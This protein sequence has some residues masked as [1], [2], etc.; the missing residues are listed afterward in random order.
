MT[1]ALAVPAR[2]LSYGY[3]DFGQRVPRTA[4]DGTVTRY[5]YGGDDLL[6]ELDGAGSPVR[7]YTY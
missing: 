6:M 1:G 5:L 2:A 7:E 4:P 3:N